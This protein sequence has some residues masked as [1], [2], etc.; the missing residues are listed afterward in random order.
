MDRKRTSR[1]K[2]VVISGPSGAG[3]TTL[4]KRIFLKRNI[5][6]S[7]IKGISYTT[8]PRRRGEK[9]GRDYYFVDKKTFRSLIRKNFFLEYQKVLED[10]YGT[11]KYFLNKGRLA[12]KDVVLC[13]DVKG[14]MYLKKNVKRDKIVTLFISAPTAE[15]LSKRLR[16]RGDMA[17]VNK[18]IALAKKELQ[19]VKVYDYLI[20]NQNIKEALSLLEAVL[21]AERLRRDR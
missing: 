1:I 15:E 21:I 13:I 12:G 16:K 20:I 18:R 19:F 2:I 4:L 17:I 3:K 8:R 5:R 10:Y 7:F 6:S 14:G 9:N 11:P